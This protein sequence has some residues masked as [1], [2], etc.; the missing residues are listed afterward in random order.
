MLRI[1]HVLLATPDLDHGAEQLWRGHGLRCLPGGRHRLWGTANLILPIGSQYL[2]L[3]AVEDPELAR[4]SLLGRAVLASADRDRLTAIGVCLAAPE[5]A[6]VAERLGQPAEPGSRQLADGTEIHWITVG[7]ERAFGAERLPFFIAWDRRD[8]HPSSA[9][10][11][12]RAAAKEISA[13]EIGGPQD[14]LRA[15]LGE[16]V[17]GVC[18]VGGPP[19]IRSVTLRLLDGAEVELI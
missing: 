15:H 3:V 12:H 10:S 7:L 6:A 14:T 2:E 8:Q 1:D 13:V 9:P 17:P 19:G 16:D 4:S 11:H 18:A 5:I